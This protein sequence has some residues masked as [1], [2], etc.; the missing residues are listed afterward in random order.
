MK[1]RQLFSISHIGKGKS[2]RYTSLLKC[3]KFKE[4]RE[5]GKRMKGET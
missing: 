4:R 5:K 1:F 2:K 3:M